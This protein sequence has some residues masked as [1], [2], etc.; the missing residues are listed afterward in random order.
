MSEQNT[1]GLDKPTYGNI[2]IPSNTGFWGFPKELSNLAIVFII[3]AFFSQIL[4]GMINQN[5]A[6][7]STALIVICGIGTIWYRIRRGMFGRYKYQERHLKKLF[8]KA[9]K[10]GKTEYR[11]GPASELPDGSY[12]APGPLMATEL[13]DWA[14]SRGDRWAMLWNG[15]RRTGTIWFSVSTS[16]LQLRD[17]EDINNMVSAWAAFHRQTGVQGTILQV[18]VSTVSTTDSGYR[19]P[20]AVENMRKHARGKKVA[21]AATATLD[22]V[23]AIENTALPRIEHLITLTFSARAEPSIGILARSDQELADE[24]STVIDGF[25]ESLAASARG[26]VN[27]MTY[28]DVTDYVYSTFNPSQAKSVDIARQNG[29]TGLRW[30]EAGP[31]YHNVEKDWYEHAGY[32]SK[33]FQMWKPPASVFYEDSMVDLLAPDQR[34]THKRVTLLYRPL[35][36]DVSSQKALE[37]VNN[38]K[39]RVGQKKRQATSEDKTAA[40]K[41]EHTENEMGLGATLVPFSLLVTITVDDVEK[42]PQLTA[43]TN[44]R[45]GSK[46]NLRLREADYS[47]DFSFAL[48]LG[49]GTIPLDFKE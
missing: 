29:G 42:F 23:V 20:L 12:R 48:S 17:Q 46:I 41:A 1:H 9:K 18:A 21:A 5:L 24:I 3:A 26:S 35:P 14:S 2:I 49:A 6:I 39:W 30:E 32:Y 40:A 10:E 33:T 13:K 31:T 19:L 37:A 36:P 43:D 44:R 22:E 38:A 47:Q 8:L 25:K 16:G 34:I 15:V 28:Q 27:L 7:A 11:P 45:G 4:V